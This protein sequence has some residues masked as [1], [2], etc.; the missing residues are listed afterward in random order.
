MNKKWV[1][2]GAVVAAL[3]LGL[4]LGSPYW[5]A[6][7]FVSA[8]RS[9]DVDRL[10]AAVDFP[11]VRQSLKSQLSAL[12]TKQLNEDP[13]MRGNPFAGLG[14]LML[15]TIIDRAVDAYVTPDAFSVMAKSGRPKANAGP[16]EA[17]NAPSEPGS[18]FDY[19]SLDRFRM[20]LHP[21]DGSEGPRFLFERRGLISWKVVRLE[22]PANIFDKRSSDTN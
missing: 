14:M 8:A 1:I 7:Q 20:T 15:P 12:L 3:A 10:E 17:G 16:A 9:A 4:Y 18:T 2:V 11:E 6:R 5:A 22:L 13:E 19:V 21:K